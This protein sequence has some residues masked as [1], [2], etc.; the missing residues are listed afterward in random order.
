[1][2]QIVARHEDH[3]NGILIGHTI[4]MKVKIHIL[5]GE[6]LVWAGQCTL[7]CLYCEPCYHHN[8]DNFSSIQ[9]MEKTSLL[10]G[11]AASFVSSISSNAKYF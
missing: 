3:L 11:G 4:F 5:A 1:M 9:T 6:V 2:D 10:L 8:A 7:T